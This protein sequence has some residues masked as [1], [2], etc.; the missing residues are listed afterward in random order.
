VNNHFFLDMHINTLKLIV[1]GYNRHRTFTGLNLLSITIGLFV[2]YITV[3]YLKFEQGY[4][5]FHNKHPNLYRMGWN[6]RAQ[7]YSVIGFPPDADASKQLLQVEALK[8][9][10]G[11]V[12]VLQMY[13]GDHAQLVTVG[14]QV[15]NCENI[16]TTNTP[17]AFVRMFSWQTRQGSTANFSEGSD[18][19][20]LTVSTAQKL[21][22]VSALKSKDW[23]TTNITVNGKTYQIAAIVDDVP[24]NSHFDFSVALS[25]PSI[26][27]WGSR[28]Y[29][30]REDQFEQAELERNLSSALATFNPRLRED[31]LHGG[32]F[33][34]PLSDIHLRSNLLYEIKTPGNPQYITLL[35][36]FG[37]FILAITL[38]N[39]T[40]LSLAIKL[41][42]IK[43][44]G[45]QR[46]LG[47]TNTA[48]GLHLLIE[49][50]LLALLALP[51]VGWLLYV[52]VP[53]FNELM[54]TDI[55]REIWRKPQAILEVVALSLALGVLT[56]LPSIV[57]VISKNTLHLF[58]ES[59]SKLT[60]QRLP[61]RKGLMIGQMA[62]LICIT[63]VSY[64]VMR[65]IWFIE[66]KD[67]GFRQEGIL[68]AYTSEE[69]QPLFQAQLRQIPEITAVGN[70]S[71]FGINPFNQM[72][73]K[74][75]DRDLVFDDASQLYLDFEALKAY[76]LKTSL[77]A[78]PT[79]RTTLINRTA[80]EKL[81]KIKGVTPQDLI[82]TVVLTEP[83]YTDPTTGQSGFIFTIDGIFEDIHL[84]SLHEKME[85][86]FITLSAG[87]RMDGRSIIAC[88]PNNT[89]VVMKKIA[90]IYQ[91]L[92]ES[93]P[94]NLELQTDNLTDLYAR[95]HQTAKLLIALNAIAI[96]LA[97]LGIIGMTLFTATA[98]TKEIG[99]RKVL[100]ASR[101]S[102]VALMGAEHGTLVAIA[103]CCGWL[104]AYWITSQ[105]LS[106]FSYH[107]DIKQAIFV[108]VS[109]GAFFMSAMLVALTAFRAAS[110]NPVKSLRSE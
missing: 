87:V 10:T 51:L 19:A 14:N 49:S 30:E 32:H 13:I 83:E 60:A 63:S 40:N 53:Y 6:Y 52:L 12:D 105:W 84:F 22:G 74:L 36:L 96:L 97:S 104:P 23:Q 86:Y 61:L 46:A 16:L 88:D 55:P 33:L 7:Q 31:P 20:I 80:A 85:P 91:G 98:K 94:L 68:Y 106:N 76:N 1:R 5:T 25:V 75:P 62:M 90:D 27:Y 47:A 28:I 4:D 50:V 78:V 59:A 81:A 18:K 8:K 58:K 3:N 89:K 37:L 65:Q 15:I 101:W 66:Q 17:G 45:V 108:F 82:G 93:S 100:G 77:L 29:I 56:A 54:Q 107:I 70:G 79:T 34:Q 109:I 57:Y 99:I 11:V 35:G 42:E 26:D 72:T 38:F 2:A 102:I 92:N 21:L 9:A 110:A 39:Y 48:L 67:L 71:S 24:A 73:Y 95:D 44:L 69:K 103:A 41:K 43:T 64:F